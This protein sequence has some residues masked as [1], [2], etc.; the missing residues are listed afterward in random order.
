M[1][2]LVMLRLCF[3]S[4]APHTAGPPTPPFSGPARRTYTDFNSTTNQFYQATANWTWGTCTYGDNEARGL[5]R[6]CM[7]VPGWHERLV[8]RCDCTGLA[9]Q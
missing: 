2:L 9:A 6:C 8:G 3:C 5:L 7:P 4:P 1:P